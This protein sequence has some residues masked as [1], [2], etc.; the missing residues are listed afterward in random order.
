MPTTYAH[1]AFGKAVFQ[2]LAPEL[3]DIVLENSMA[4]QIGLHG[5]DIFAYYKPLAQNR[6]NELA[7]RLH[8]EAATGVFKRCK[9]L[10]KKEGEPALMAYTMGLICHFMLDSSC[11]SFLK[12]YM[13]ETGVGREELEA[14]FDRVLMEKDALNPMTW[15]PGSFIRLEKSYLKVICQVL[16]SLTEKEL[17]DTL[18]S[19][20]FYTGIIVRPTAVGRKMVLTGMKVLKCYDEMQGRVMRKRPSKRCEKG[21]A[22][23]EELFHL[24]VPETVTV[25]EDFCRTVS[26]TEYINGRFEQKFSW[27]N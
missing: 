15:R 2:K 27:R 16:P 14:E 9:E 10:L 5:P 17:K 20:R 1:N 18:R 24:A 11:Y 8:E 22:R 6:I 21:M 4:Y 13:K 12:H 19:M 23:L 25:I 26:D 3:K 7:R